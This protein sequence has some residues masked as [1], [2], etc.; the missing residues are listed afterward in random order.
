MNIKEYDNLPESMKPKDIHAYCLQILKEA[1]TDTRE[2]TLG[3]LNILGDK[4]WHTY[5][6]LPMEVRIKIR[7]W[8]IQNWTDNSQQY[9]EDVM[10]I[11]YC[12]ALEKGIFAE[13]LK[14]Y[15]GEHKKE[16]EDNLANSAGDHID[17][18]WSMRK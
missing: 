2:I 6:L 7:E 4:Q 15:R 14:L 9:L 16:F 5:E 8:L 10:G 3:K 18:W 13:A 17:P 11:A 12:Y 1:N